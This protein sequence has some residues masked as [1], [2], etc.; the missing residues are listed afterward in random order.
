MSGYLQLVEPGFGEGDGGDGIEM[1]SCGACGGI[2]FKV[3]SDETGICVQCD[4]VVDF[5]YDD[6]TDT[7]N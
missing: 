6:S 5:D 3:L 7:G 1:F 4:E 2:I